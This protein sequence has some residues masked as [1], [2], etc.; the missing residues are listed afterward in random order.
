MSSE[1][2]ETY[3]HTR[4]RARSSLEKT[5]MAEK[6]RGAAVMYAPAVALD[7]F[8]GASVLLAAV[9]RLPDPERSRAARILR[10]MMTVGALAPWV[11]LLVIRPWQMN[12]GATDEE[13]R[14]RLPGDELVPHPALESTR[15]VTIGA[16]VEEVWRWLVQLGQD[17]G[18][19]Y[20]YDLLENLAGARIHNVDRIVPEMQDLKVGDFVPMAPVEWNVP[21]GGFTVVE[22]EPQCAI[23][24]RQG[25]PEDL[26]NMNPSEGQERGTWAFVL[27]TI[28]EGTT[29]LLLRERSGHK[30]RT[31]DV[32]FH[33]LFME[34]QHFVMERRMLKG[35]K[36]RAER[37][38]S[39]GNGSMSGKVVLITGGTAGIGKAT[40]EGL[41]SVGASVVVVGRDRSTGEAAVA[42]IR[43]TSGNEAVELMVADLSSQAE[44][45][46]LVE[47]FE[48]RNERL[49]VLINNAGAMYP[50]RWE[51]EDGIE[52][53]F[54]VNHLA[55]VLLTTLLLPMLRR[56][57]HSRI[58][59]VNSWSHRRA[60]LDLD[61]LQSEERYSASRAYSRA[62][63]INLLWTYELAR[64]LEGTGVTVNVAD[65]G[66]ASTAMTRSEAM[67]L[68]FRT[69]NRLGKNLM[70]T[71]KAARS[72]IYLASSAKVEGVNGEYFEP[73][74]KR[75][76]SSKASYDRASQRRIW[77]VSAEL[78]K[79]ER[80]LPVQEARRT[81]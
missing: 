11:Y 25:W 4:P 70:T 2:G 48:S 26:E 50:R 54:A 7:L 28:D 69:I 46:R 32:I 38:V 78:T 43:A 53:T 61:D 41:A 55:P 36:E 76:E 12:W 77:E 13:V 34:R 62:K 17:R 42:E 6:L 19:F 18:G 72:S 1:Y 21:T 40:A 47:E 29:R 73:P 64:K 65:P 15:A 16:P 56:S 57:A 27:E 74:D 79:P 23:V 8:E 22:I 14:V 67:P 24:W 35:I 20:S 49:D 80:G 71:E 51:T 33:Y 45:H 44:I 68:L 63:L 9:G 37:N 81:R 3:P 66:G 58:V 59:N 75:V 10:P 39:A 30:P 52:G 31:R 5:Y 60:K